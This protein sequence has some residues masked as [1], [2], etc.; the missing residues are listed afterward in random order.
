MTTRDTLS[1]RRPTILLVDEDEELRKTIVILLESTADVRAVA[2]AGEA[3]ALVAS[4]PFDAA[5]V[6]S[7]LDGGSGLALLEDLARTCPSTLRVLAVEDRPSSLDDLTASGAVQLQMAKPFGLQEVY[8][9][10]EEMKRRS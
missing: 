3:F 10:L 5:I 2:S 7:A 9:L 4:E 8:S 6:D 1:D